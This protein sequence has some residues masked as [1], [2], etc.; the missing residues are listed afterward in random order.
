MNGS[1]IRAGVLLP[2]RD[3]LPAAAGEV[4]AVLSAYADQAGIDLVFAAPEGTPAERARGARELV[5]K[6]QP[7]ALV[8]SFTDGADAELA[9]MADEMEVP[10]LATLSSSPRSSVASARWLRDLCGGVIEQSMALLRSFEA[11]PVALVHGD[12]EVAERIDGAQPFP[13]AE[14]SAADLRDF[15]AVLFAGAH[16]SMRR[17]LDEMRALARWP[18]ALLLAGAALAPSL[19]SGVPSGG[20][21][22]ALPTSADDQTPAAVSVY[23]DV[24]RRQR[25]PGSHRFSQFAALTSLQ[26]F[27]DAVRRCGGQPDRAA[28]LHAVDQTRRFQSGLF[29]PLTYGA[30]RHIGSTGAWVLAAHNGRESLVWVD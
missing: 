5:E 10:L 4:G 17:I 30:E 28:L 8:A 13:A 23:L 7:L 26:L 19:F 24:A 2:P 3:L 22:V 9:A 1:A 12:E 11:R 16:A 21:W 25:I 6:T 15:A 18:P 14:T 27:L 29:P 20:I